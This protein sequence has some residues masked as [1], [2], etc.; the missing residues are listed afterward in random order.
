M[1]LQIMTSEFHYLSLLS[2]TN[3][4]VAKNKKDLDY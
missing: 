2:L 3:L 1:L 4:M